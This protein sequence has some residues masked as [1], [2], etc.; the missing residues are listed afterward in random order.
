MFKHPK[1][2]QL[3]T[4]VIFL[5]LFSNITIQNQSR[6][7]IIAIGRYVQPNLDNTDVYLTITKNGN[8]K[9]LF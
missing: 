3:L 7:R 6:K 1:Q 5:S 4:A 9:V 8:T 2:P